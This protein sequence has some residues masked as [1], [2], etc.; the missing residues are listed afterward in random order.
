MTTDTQKELQA[1]LVTTLQTEMP[2]GDLLKA[3]QELSR[4]TGFRQL[5]TIWAPHLLVRDAAFFEPFLLKNLGRW[6]HT[7]LINAMLPYIEAAGH[8]TLFSQLYGRATDESA[9]NRDIA[10]LVDDPNLSDDELLIA[11]ERRSASQRW[12]RLERDAAAKLYRRNPQMFGAF[13]RQ[14]AAPRFAWYTSNDKFEELR[15]LAKQQGDDDLYWS[16][17]RI[18]A[19]DKEWN[20]ELKRL[21]KQRLPGD[22]VVAE[23]TKRHPNKMHYMN[24]EI[25]IDFLEQY[26][27]DVLPYIE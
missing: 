2:R 18:T 22:Q 7:E 14:H 10:N 19:D 8:Y 15:E 13:V 1:K 21:L 12:N 23:L 4:E 6:E 27:E 20:D 24:A 17:F 3:M 5:A 9:W 11:I 25:L 16:L 26:G